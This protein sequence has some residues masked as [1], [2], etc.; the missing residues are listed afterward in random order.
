ME[1]AELRAM[2][3]SRRKELSPS[4]V[5]D[6]SKKIQNY[7][8]E[9]EIW[10]E[11]GQVVLYSPVRNEVHTSQLFENIWST[12]KTLLLPRC[13]EQQGEMSLVE[14]TGHHDLDLGKYGI[15]EPL[16]HCTEVAYDDPLLDPSLV[17]VPGVGFD[18]LGHRIGFGG[19]YYDRMLS[20]AAFNHA[21]FVGFAYSFQVVP[22]LKSDSWDQNMHA[23]CTEEG[24]QWV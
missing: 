21:T 1:K 9:S 10:A 8:L 18:K 12:G 23:L 14:C 6:E 2:L 4:F 20:K 24:F 5:F 13:G 11:A 7:M 15:L 3:L 17:I 22:A 16:E 19:G